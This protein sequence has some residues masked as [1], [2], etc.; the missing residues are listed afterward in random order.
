MPGFE[1]L[2]YATTLLFFIF[3]PF[4]TVPMFI[5]L[6]RDQTSKEQM[7]SANKAVLVAPPASAAVGSRIDIAGAKP[8][9]EIRELKL[10]D[11][12]KVKLSVKNGNVLCGSSLLSVNVAPVTCAVSD[13]S[14]VH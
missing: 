3:D 10:K 11:L 2:I 5:T 4:A 13:G 6:T 12:D 8:D 7:V 14:G 9:A 1:E